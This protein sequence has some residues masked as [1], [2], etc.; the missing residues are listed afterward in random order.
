MPVATET[1]NESAT[2]E[3]GTL[4][5]E[6]VTAP[7]NAAD[8]IFAREDNLLQAAP[9]V[10]DV[11]IAEGTWAIQNKRIYICN[12]T[13]IQTGT[14][15]DNLDKWD[16]LISIKTFE[17]ILTTPEGVVTDNIGNLVLREVA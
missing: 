15:D 11:S 2:P 16:P 9:F 5:I 12:E 8:T 14:F 17:R 1:L 10:P 4:T 13:G 6:S 7:A 3:A